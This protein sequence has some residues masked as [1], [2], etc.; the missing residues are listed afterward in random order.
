MDYADIRDVAI[1]DAIPNYQYDKTILNIGCG[2]GRIDRILASMGYRVYA[3]DCRHHSI[4]QD[5]ENITFHITDIFKTESFPIK[6]SP[7]VICSEVLEHLS[8]Y[9]VAIQKLLV[10]TTTR[11][12][13]TVPFEQSF[14]NQSPPPIG[15]CNHWGNKKNKIFG[16]NGELLYILNDINEFRDICK[17]YSVSISKIRTKPGDVAMNQWC[18]LV[19]ID[20]RQ[21]YG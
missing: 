6:D 17:P 16:K 5:T 20:K 15:H 19:V 13:I 10:M 8:N 9:R 18:Y 12:I 7:V 2:A 21:K 4:W 1:I 3:T 11:L 14:N